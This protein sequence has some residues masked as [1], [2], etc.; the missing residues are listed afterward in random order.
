MTLIAT[1][2]AFWIRAEAEN[3]A[4]D[5]AQ[6]ITQRLADYAV[7]PLIND[8]L[9][10]GDP[11]AIEELDV[12]LK[13]WLERGAVLRIK[14]WD[15]DGR[16][17]YSD[18]PSLIGQQFDL[19]APALG[20]LAGASGTTSLEDQQGLENEYEA[21]SGELVEVYVGSLAATGAPLIFE[22]YYDDDGVRE[23]QTR[24]LLAITPIFL[25]AFGVLQLAQLIPAVRL[26]RR[27]QAH[28]VSRRK[29]LQYA[30]EASDLERRRIARD[31]HDEVIQDLAGL[32]YAMEAEEKRG[33]A[34]Q[35]PLFGRVRSIL[36][37]NLRTLRAMTSELYPPDLDTL[38]LPAAL[39]RLAESLREQGID[40]ALQVPD[41]YEM[42]RDHAVMLY[43]V[44]R[45][46]LTNTVKHAHANSV[47]LSLLREDGSTV[48]TIRD[49]GRGFN[50]EDGSP[51][52]HL[53]LRLMHDTIREAG[54]SL[55]VL[56]GGGCGTS[57][58]ATLS[59]IPSAA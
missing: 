35:R 50:P 53:G 15:G 32:S 13:P 51:E 23:E 9:I 1:P 12:R 55:Q 27:I 28:E 39:T 14:V 25:L 38:G 56:S 57:V 11:A 22:A 17:I 29:L 52:G 59:R 49:D 45:E 3:H 46:V 37:E 8:R 43:R 26:A 21:D 18:V 19:P 34:S 44:A 20:L 16:I 47:H 58:I 33:A 4:L 6:R 42:D 48:L 5:N 2:V 54:G 40:V 36:Q 30:I 41:N 31:L 24:V 7:S 10:A